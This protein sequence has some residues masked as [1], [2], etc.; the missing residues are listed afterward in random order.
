[1][2]SISSYIVDRGLNATNNISFITTTYVIGA[3]D[4]IIIATLS[5]TIS[6]TYSVTLPSAASAGVG[7]IFTVRNTSGT[8]SVTKTGTD[9]INGANTAISVA[10]GT[11]GT[12]F[13][14]DG[15][16]AYYTI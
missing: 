5:P 8:S 1:M 3:N 7:K 11:T 4:S 15:T 2:A 14:S 10:T 9:T 13:L 12:R 6:T 16:S